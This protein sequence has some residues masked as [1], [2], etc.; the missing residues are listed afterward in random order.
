MSTGRSERSALA[1]LWALREER[2][3]TVWVTLLTLAVFLVYPFVDWYLRPAVAV[4]LCNPEFCFND[5]GAY[6]GGVFRWLNGGEIYQRMNGSFHGTYL[7]PPVTLLYFAVFQ[8]VAFELSGWLMA[9]LGVGLLWVGLVAAIELL[10]LGLSWPERVLLV[11]P[12][13]GFQPVL[14]TIKLGQVSILL[15]ALQTFALVGLLSERRLRGRDRSTRERAAGLLSGAFATLGSAFKVFYAPS[16]AHLLRSRRRLAGAVGTAGLLAAVSVAVFGV[17][18]NLRFLEV[19]AWGKGWGAA[20]PPWYWHA[21]YYKPLVAVSELSPTVSIAVR[22]VVLVGIIGLS[23]AARDGDADLATYALG[24]VA[25]PFL[26]PTAYTHD[27]VVLL[28][29][30]VVLVAVEF[31]RARAG[32]AAASWSWLARPRPWLPVLALLLLNLQAYGLKLA[33]DHLPAGAPWDTI[34]G[35]TIVLQPALWG[36][37]A[38]L[39][40][41]AHRVAASSE[42]LPV[43][44]TPAATP[45]DSGPDPVGGDSATASQD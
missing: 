37:L 22:A 6:S 10:G 33:V 20:L 4:P 26:A 9:A 32:P 5:Y 3:L 36:N 2:P 39:G 43:G 29:A 27:F 35:L 23:L 25:I 17:A 11:W 13:L 41:A 15:A 45:A 40:L 18:T 1:R 21:G 30:V 12:V 38:L 7:Y 19:L 8:G 42:R 24:V 14:Y 34:A 16:G 44:G 31:R 28:P